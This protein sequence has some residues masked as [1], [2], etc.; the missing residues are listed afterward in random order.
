MA[1]READGVGAGAHS[2][3]DLGRDHHILACDAEI[4][5]AAPE[6]PLGFT[7]G[8]DVARVEEIDAAIDRGAP[9]TRRR[10]LID[11]ADIGSYA[12][13]YSF[14]SLASMNAANSAL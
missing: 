10:F 9:K 13:A 5:K 12:A 14:G 2:P 1:A 11:L 3:A 7:L 6:K 4:L 8:I